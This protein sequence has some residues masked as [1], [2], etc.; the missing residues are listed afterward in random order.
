M[1]LCVLFF[2]N[3]T[4]LYFLVSVS[5]VDN[6]WLPWLGSRGSVVAGSSASV[7]VNMSRSRVQFHGIEKKIVIV[8]MDS[9]V[10][11]A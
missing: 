10:S 6:T 9:Q 1:C 8:G 2:L 4:P 11:P 3:I 7:L 5:W